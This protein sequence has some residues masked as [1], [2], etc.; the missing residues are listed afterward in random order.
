MIQRC[1]HCGIC[2]GGFVPPPG[3]AIDHWPEPDLCQNCIHL[4]DTPT[5]E[6]IAMSALLARAAK[7]TEAIRKAEL[8]GERVTAEVI[9]MILR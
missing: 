9:E 3:S 8:A 2:A 1:R 7:D 6:E 5:P 4:R